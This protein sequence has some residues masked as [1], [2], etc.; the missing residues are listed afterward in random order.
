MCQVHKILSTFN[1]KNCTFRC[2]L[3]FNRLITNIHWRMVWLSC[4]LEL[5]AKIA[6][7][8]KQHGMVTQ[9]GICCITTFHTHNVKSLYMIKYSVTWMNSHYHH[10]HQYHHISVIINSIIRL[11]HAGIC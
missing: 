5:H 8:T 3:K 1:F 10:H 4:S 2:K 7:F 6:S 9:T 11:K